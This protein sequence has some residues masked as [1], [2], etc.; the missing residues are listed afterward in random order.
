M[1]Q[2]ANFK[3]ILCIGRICYSTIFHR[4]VPLN[5]LKVDGYVGVQFSFFYD[6]A[7][8]IHEF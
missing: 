1:L 6:F 5:N 4:L 7:H 2:S 3:N 8:S